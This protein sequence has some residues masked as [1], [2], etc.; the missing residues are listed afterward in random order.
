[1]SASGSPAWRASS[2]ARSSAGQTQTAAWR[3][4]TRGQLALRGR[5]V[6]IRRAFEVLARLEDGGR[7]RGEELGEDVRRTLA[8]APSRRHPRGG[9]LAK[10]E[11][12]VEERGLGTSTLASTAA[13]WRR[14]LAVCRLNGVMP[15]WPWRCVMPMRQK[16]PRT[17]RSKQSHARA[18]SPTDS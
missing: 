11:E 9:E 3:T 2:T 12:R 18:A 4:R 13:R 7:A 8:A 10:Q 1:M 14:P 15:S 17:P 5:K 6:E 16:Q